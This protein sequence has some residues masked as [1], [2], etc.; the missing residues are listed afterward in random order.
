MGLSKNTPTLLTSNEPMG[1]G[2]HGNPNSITITAT[3]WLWWA[4]NIRFSNVVFPT[5][6]KHVR[7]VTG[8]FVCKGSP[9]ELES[10][11]MGLVR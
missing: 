1:H 11:S 4:V 5:P 2:P 8:I 9:V 6:N 3:R 7:M 10:R